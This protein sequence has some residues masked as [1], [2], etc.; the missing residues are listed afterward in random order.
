MG[1]GVSK[2]LPNSS[3]WFPTPSNENFHEI[4][5]YTHFDVQE[6]QLIHEIWKIQTV[7]KSSKKDEKPLRLMKLE[8]LQK[9][10]PSI[11]INILRALFRATST[12]GADYLSFNEAARFLSD[13]FRGTEEE[14]IKWSFELYRTDD[15]IRKAN[16]IAYVKSVKPSEE[17]NVNQ[18]FGSNDHLDF[19]SYKEKCTHYKEPMN[20]FGLVNI[21]FKKHIRPN[22]EAIITAFRNDPT[23]IKKEGYVLILQQKK[24]KWKR[25]F[26]IL[27]GTILQIFSVP[28]NDRRS[29]G[30]LLSTSN[31]GNQSK[32]STKIAQ[33][34]RNI[35]VT[36]IDLSLVDT[37]DRLGTQINVPST[38]TFVLSCENTDDH[39]DWVLHLLTCKLLNDNRSNS[40]HSIN[41]NH[42]NNSITINTSS[43]DENKKNLTS[44]LGTMLLC[45]SSDE[46]DDDGDDNSSTHSLSRVRRMNTHEQLT[47]FLSDPLDRIQ[48]RWKEEIGITT[49]SIIKSFVATRPLDI[50]ET[51]IAEGPIEDDEIETVCLGS[52][53]FAKSVSTYPI[54]HKTGKKYGSP[55]CDYFRA[56]IASN[57]AI[58]SIADGCNWGHPPREA[59]R[60]AT[61]AFVQYLQRHSTELNDLNSVR[62][63]LL[64]ALTK[65]HNNILDGGER[66]GTCTLLGGL[67]LPVRL[68]I[69]AFKNN[70]TFPFDNQ[71][72]FACANV[73]DCKAFHFSNICKSVTDVTYAFHRTS[74]N[75]TDPGGRLGPYVDANK[76][77]LRNL[78]LY[79][80]I[81]YPGDIIIL[82]T[83][84]VHDN[85]D[86]QQLGFEP[87]EIGH[88][89]TD[90]TELSEADCLALKSSY[91][92]QFMLSKVAEAQKSQTE[93]AGI[94][95][96]LTNSI[97]EHC[98]T[99][100]SNSREY[101]EKNPK[102]RSPASR[103]T[104][105]GKMDHTTV[106]TF[107][108]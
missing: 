24:K 85:I 2:K 7:L 73:G 96:A 104:Y 8:T 91:V 21:I 30:V 94:A 39:D 46:L 28:S 70:E 48:W 79:I 9:L 47:F 107:L 15:H 105:P 83:D 87:N 108:V 67:L 18:L 71:R 43:E 34:L 4:A 32:S 55:I 103:K 16:L 50:L 74:T 60:R 27:E 51:D 69:E 20:G 45:H 92:S 22:V 40:I 76:A 44:K 65:A 49:E 41:N 93:P 84:G 68:D 54:N 56:G 17:E 14:K 42:N 80:R 52:R 12:T 53:L 101:M 13:C 11:D 64:A 98:I 81:C 62:K 59:A 99:I 95:K 35:S 75:T 1:T 89:A 23:Q 97:I 3:Q 72:I 31:I 33:P 5:N 37:E 100:T 25:A 26:A 78:T 10:C 102:G 36:E 90:W 86:P 6:L 88:T 58:L 63:V 82:T 77:D 38:P 106:V 61:E 29:T 57:N 66:V 19:E